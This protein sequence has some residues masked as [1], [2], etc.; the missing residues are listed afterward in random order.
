MYR[1]RSCFIFTDYDAVNERSEQCANATELVREAGGER[2]TNSVVGPLSTTPGQG[3]RIKH[4]SFS[5]RVSL[6]GIEPVGTFRFKSDL[7][8]HCAIVQP[9]LYDCVMVTQITLSRRPSESPR[10]S[11]KSADRPWWLQAPAS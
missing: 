11:G 2:F 8:S 3:L 7:R 4:I 1:A 9:R 6:A 5:V 10:T